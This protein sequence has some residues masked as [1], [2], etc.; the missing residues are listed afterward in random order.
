MV[1]CFASLFMFR[2]TS[3]H[4]AMSGQVRLYSQYG[5]LFYGRYY[6]GDQEF[7]ML[8]YD[9]SQTSLE[10]EDDMPVGA[11]AWPVALQWCEHLGDC[12]KE[13]LAKDDK[14]LE[15]GAG[16]GVVGIVLAALCGCRAVITD[17]SDP[18][19]QIMRVNVQLNRGALLA[20]SGEDAW[21]ETA[22]VVEVERLSFGEKSL[23][24]GHGYKLIVASDVCYSERLVEPLFATV[25]SSLMKEGQ[26]LLGYASRDQLCNDSLLPEAAK[27]H[28][29]S[30]ED[31]T[32][33]AFLEGTLY[34]CRLLGD[35]ENA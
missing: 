34:R 32:P 4:G 28:G 21:D 31:I 10:L 12:A 14:I 5:F 19:L 27:K 9:A 26:F 16:I 22:P 11:A 24:T 33:A 6:F 3:V 15:L 35:P 23:N 30:L 2:H 20:A 8:E 7:R 29:L 25:A 17:N 18:C 13:L 1:A